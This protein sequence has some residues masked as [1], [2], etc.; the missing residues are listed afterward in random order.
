M[1]SVAESMPVEITIVVQGPV[2]KVVTHA[3][4]RQPR[5]GHIAAALKGDRRILA[6]RQGPY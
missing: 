1:I 4:A 5:Y 3:R 2:F 6:G